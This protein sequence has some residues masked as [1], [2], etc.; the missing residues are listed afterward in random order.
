MKLDKKPLTANQYMLALA[1]PNQE[2]PDW[3]ADPVEVITEADKTK[4]DIKIELS[5]GGVLDVKITDAVSKEPVE[6]AR[7]GVNSQTSNQSA[8]SRT[9]EDGLAQMRLMPGDY[10]VTYL[11]K[12]GYSQQ[13]L[14]DTVTIEDGKTQHLEYELVGMPKITGIVCDQEN[15]PI[16]GVEMEICPRGGREDSVSNAEGKFEVTYDLGGWPSGRTPTIFLIGR[17]YE[18]N[19]AAAIQ[20]DEDTREL[21]MKLEPAV[22]L[23]GQV[24]D[25][26]D[27]GIAD[28]EVRSM[29]QGPQWGSTIGR[30]AI[31][32]DNDGKYQIKALPPGRTYSIYARAEGYGESHS[33]QISTEAAVDNRVDA[34]KLTMTV[35][36]L[37]ISGVVVDDNNK[38]VA[39]AR[40][41]SYGDNQPYRNAQTDVDG[42]F[43]LE[44][45]CAGKI[46]ISANKTAATRLYGYIETE[47]G[48]T[49][50]RVVISERPSS[51]RYEPKRPPSLVGRPLPNLKD[52]GI[53]LTAAETDGKMILV[54]FFDM[55]QRPSRN[56]VMQ[57][58]GQAGQLEEKGLIVVTV[59]TSQ[60]DEKTLNEWVRDNNIRLPVG[61][62]KDDEKETRFNWGVESL[63][64]LILTD[65]K[66]IVR[67]AGFRIDDLNEKIGEMTNV[68]R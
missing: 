17:Q 35:A 44:K 62:I 22:T 67:A 39:G 7:V 50:V 46:R 2:L 6:D 12:Q 41:N 28:V 56:C 8:Y 57:L 53:D 33:E 4:S 9:N 20:V 52:V 66:H 61:I 65:S 54:C 11:Y 48:A 10:Q 37:S 63:P 58:T 68:E 49:D 30:K 47:G 40:I 5:K 14:Q 51:M 19:L 36:N 13:R 59:Q 24:V 27:K 23:T 42:K 26:N 60:V 16:E 29:L 15:K 55:E 38:P 32:T 43:T 34:G 64:W 45:V 31:N 18:R 21:E 25:V 3:V 1:Q